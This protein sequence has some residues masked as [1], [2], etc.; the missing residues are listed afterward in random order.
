MVSEHD[1]VWSAALEVPGIQAI[2][3][4]ED[5]EL[6]SVSC[7]SAGSCAAGGYY[8]DNNADGPFLHPWAVSENNGR[9]GRAEEPS[10]AAPNLSLGAVYSVSCPSAGD[11]SGRR[12]YPQRQPKSN[13]A[14]GG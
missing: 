6:D 8:Y 5:A 2:N 3:I 14:L 11:C 4:G 9:W 7:P 1:G 10:G 13:L 12:G